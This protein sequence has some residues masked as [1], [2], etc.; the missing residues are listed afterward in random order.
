MKKILRIFTLCLIFGLF[1]STSF[2]FAGGEQ[3]K[4][5]AAK[6]VSAP[7][8]GT[9]IWEVHELDAYEAESGKKLTFTEAPMFAEM[10][11]AGTLKPVEERLPKEPLVVQPA[12]SVGKYGDQLTFHGVQLFDAGQFLHM[13]I[14]IG[15]DGM[16]FGGPKTTPNAMKGDHLSADRKTYT[17]Y[18][19]EGLKWSDGDPCDADDIMFWFN[20]IAND[21]AQTAWY[22]K[23]WTSWKNANVRIERVND[24]EVKFHFDKPMFDPHYEMMAGG[25]RYLVPSH[26]MKNFHIKYNK[27]AD[28]LANEYGFET[29]DVLLSLLLTLPANAAEELNKLVPTL[30]PWIFVRDISGGVLFE[31]NPYFY[32]VDTEGQQLPYQ[33]KVV[34]LGVEDAEVYKLK[35]LAGEID[36]GEGGLSTYPL[37]AEEAQKGTL[38]VDTRPGFSAGWVAYFFNLD[39]REDPVIGKILQDKRFRQALSLA[40]DRDYINETLYY[41]KA[42]PAQLTIL[43]A[44]SLYEEKWAQSYAEYNEKKANSLLD[45]MGLVWDADHKYRLR[46]D[47]K[48]LEVEIM[49]NEAMLEYTTTLEIVPDYWEAVGIKV[50]RNVVDRGFHAEAHKASQFQISQRASHY[51]WSVAMVATSGS[52]DLQPTAG[53]RGFAPRW[54]VWADAYLAGEGKEVAEDE[55]PEPYKEFILTLKTLQQL[56]EE[57]MLER[58]KWIFDFQAEY[59]MGIG[60]VA[61]P[62]YIMVYKSDLKNVPEGKYVEGVH[63]TLQKPQTFYRD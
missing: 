56:P 59:L 57:E 20:D 40:M 37:F 22:T 35:L 45:E 32:E 17:V 28:K 51:M 25:T 53:R 18:M 19:R 5:A 58:V 48:V 50:V 6:E 62:P 1:A 39:Y 14:N 23:L 12:G 26:V 11:S 49:A 43:P 2:V 31:R 52:F 21:P 8:T 36:Y 42:T 54:G 41:G 9:G 27:D 55:P 4:P 10:V 33:D 44:S 3:E 38:K 34:F 15:F 16:G 61:Q 47:G 13:T 46:P 60:T 24:Y 29:W 7:E 30:T 63:F